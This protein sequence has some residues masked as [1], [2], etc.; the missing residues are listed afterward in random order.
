MKRAI[1]TLAALAA[2]GALGALLSIIA[3]ALPLMG[4]PSLRST[5]EGRTSAAIAQEQ[6]P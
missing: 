2:G 6:A 1:E 4:E 5:A 3:G